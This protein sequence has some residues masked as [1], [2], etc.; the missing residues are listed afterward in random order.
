[1]LESI[2]RL[3]QVL[4]KAIMTMVQFL[5][6]LILGVVIAIVTALP[7]LLR[8]ASVL[9]WLTGGYF[10]LQAIQEIYGP[11]SPAGPVL[12][13]QFAVIFLMTAWVGGLLLKSLTH[14]WGGLLAGGLFSIWLTRSVVPGFITSWQHA[15]FLFRVLPPALLAMT[16]LSMTLRLRRL[17]STRNL[18]L[19]NPAFIWLP[20]AVH[21]AKETFQQRGHHE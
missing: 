13:L 10:A 14:L 16:L 1:M 8:I 5:I 11:N 3:A 17:R 19:V 12:A 15:D 6:I 2:G 7:W 9:V 21:Q 4:V 20:K 18:K